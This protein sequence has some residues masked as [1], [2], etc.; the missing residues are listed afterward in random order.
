MNCSQ[1]GVMSMQ[2]AMIYIKTIREDQRISQKVIAEKMREFLRGHSNKTPSDRQVR[3]WENGESEPSASELTALLYSVGGAIE[4]V[5]RLL[6][7][8]RADEEEG[9]K[10]AREWINKPIIDYINGVTD[11]IPDH[12]IDDVRE[13]IE[14]LRDLQRQNKLEKLLSFGR[15]LKNDL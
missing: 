9:K 6:V 4:D 1:G 7:D 5:Y 13:G 10:L 15:F 8:A 3:R 11:K 12:Q 14:L 2:A